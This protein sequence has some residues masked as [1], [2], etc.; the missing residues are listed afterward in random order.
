MGRIR[1]AIRA[2]RAPE[3]PLPVSTQTSSFISLPYIDP[4]EQ[5]TNSKDQSKAFSGWVYACVRTIAQDVRASQWELKGEDGDIF[6]DVPSILLRP[7]PDMTWGD[8]IEITTMHLDLTGQSLWNVV[9]N[10]VRG[11]GQPIGLQPIYPHWIDDVVLDPFGRRVLRWRVTVDGRTPREIEAE[12]VLRF[13]YPHPLDPHR[14]ASP[15]EAFA[16]SYDMDVYARAYGSSLLKNFAQPPGIL[17]SDQEITPEQADAIRERWSAQ[18]QEAEKIA[19]LGKG[20]SYQPM[21]LSIK[22]LAFLDLAKMNRDQILGIYGVPATKLGLGDEGGTRAEHDARDASYKENVIKPRLDRVQEVINTFL[23]PRLGVPDNVTFQFENPVRS[24]ESFELM[25]AN[26][27]LSRG[28]LRVNQYLQETGR[29]PIDGPDGELFLMPS[30]FK[31]VESISDAVSEPDEPEAPSPTLVDDSEETGDDE[32]A[33]DQ[34]DEE[35]LADRLFD[36]LRGFLPEIFKD[37]WT[38]KD[39]E[40]AEL[41]FLNALSPHENRLESQVQELFAKEARLVAKKLKESVVPTARMQWAEAVRSEGWYGE[42]WVEG[43]DF[44]LEWPKRDAIDQALREMADEWRAVMEAAF[45]NG[46]ELGWDLLERD[47]ARTL[48]D[49]DLF[50]G[51]AR[52]IAASHAGDQIVGIS[53]TTKRSVRRVIAQS[54]VDGDAVQKTAT[55]VIQTYNG[56]KKSRARTI[57]RTEIA[58]AVNR[59]KA[60]HTRKA[61]ERLGVTIMKTWLATL[62]DRVRDHHAAAHGLR[63]PNNELFRVNGELL[64]YPLDEE[65]GASAGNIINCR[66]TTI[67]EVVDP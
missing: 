66:C 9:T 38:T 42:P 56:F 16:L 23:L 50:L 13:Y 15:V 2:L 59:G 49:F 53:Q 34:L 65:H 29:E 3:L 57:A 4:T 67:T 63:V 41:R 52:I 37:K 24:D 58:A 35:E 5:R 7:L 54:I 55:K 60:E 26:E 46:L 12:D 44:A 21:A 8:I 11:R 6:E 10:G 19:V 64:A 62:D 43:M 51:E 18:R 31:A 22:D 27:G 48:I 47:A 45:L 20:A 30:G 40:L 33:S 61:E 1:N 25:R 28:V 36:R 32:A 39:Y 14:G 17:T